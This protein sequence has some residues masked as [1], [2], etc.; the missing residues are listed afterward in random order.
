MPDRDSAADIGADLL[1]AFGFLTRLPVPARAWSDGTGR[2]ARAAWAFPVVG[3]AVGTLAATAWLAADLIGLPPL[4]CGALAV[5]ATVAATGGLHEDGLADVAD[6]A[7]GGTPERRLDIMRDS[8]L[9]SYGALAILFAVLVRVGV[10]GSLDGADA[11]FALFLAAESFSRALLPQA[12]LRLPPARP[13]GLG[14][15]AG[16]PSEG[17]VSAALLIGLAIA[18]AAL[19]PLPGLLAAALGGAA[20]WA[21][22]AWAMRR[23]G[24]QTGD[25]LG[26]MQ[27]CGGIGVLIGGVAGGTL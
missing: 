23:L 25:V 11:A 19:G 17:P 16:K 1:L 24:G 15:A 20:G 3:L 18:L 26:A 10:Y 27:M 13:D 6:G 5:L 12:M 14:R 7:G 22:A 2:L 21:V 4:A 8:R 9:G